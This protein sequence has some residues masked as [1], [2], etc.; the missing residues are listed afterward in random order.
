MNIPPEEECNGVSDRSQNGNKTRTW[1]K[2]QRVVPFGGHCRCCYVCIVV[3]V[4]YQLCCTQYVHRLSIRGCSLKYGFANGLPSVQVLCGGKMVNTFTWQLCKGRRHV[5]DASKSRTTLVWYH[6]RLMKVYFLESILSVSLRIKPCNENTLTYTCPSEDITFSNQSTSNHKV[7]CTRLLVTTAYHLIN[8]TLLLTY[9]GECLLWK[10][11]RSKC[12]L[13]VHEKVSF[14]R[15]RQDKIKGLGPAVLR[16]ST[17]YLR[18][19]N[20]A[21]PGNSYERVDITTVQLKEVSAGSQIYTC[22]NG[23]TAIWRLP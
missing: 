8:R 17:T 5:V 12:Q 23:R 15:G 16:S 18:T 19:T 22:G 9:P 3:R 2:L 6:T 4:I 7:N 13:H 14:F 20:W 10:R 11:I 21:I 1:C